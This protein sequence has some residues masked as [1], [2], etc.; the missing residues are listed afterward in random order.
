MKPTKRHSDPLGRSRTRHRY[1][2]YL[3]SLA[4]AITGSVWPIQARS[5]EAIFDTIICSRRPSSSSRRTNA[6]GYRQRKK[7]NGL[8]F[9]V[10]LWRS[11]PGRRKCSPTPSSTTCCERWT[12]FGT[13]SICPW[14]GGT[15]EPRCASQRYCGAT[16]FSR[17]S[18]ESTAKSAAFGFA[19]SRRGGRVNRRKV[20]RI[21][22]CRIF[23]ER[24]RR[25]GQVETAGI[26]PAD[27]PLS[28]QPGALAIA[29]V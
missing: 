10:G 15:A 8:T 5:I 16:S 14:S 4:I 6:G 12:F 11:I 20:Q 3:L 23:G 26:S 28:G 25:S 21:P 9:P 2:R 29:Q 13:C 18:D 24:K 19:G 1:S 27:V 22:V 17:T 7:L